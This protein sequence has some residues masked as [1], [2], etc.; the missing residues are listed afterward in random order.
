MPDLHISRGNS[1]IGYIPNVSLD[2]RKTCVDR[3]CRS[4][5]YALKGQCAAPDTRKA[6]AENYALYLNEPVTYFEEIRRFLRRRKPPVFRFH[7]GGDIPGP[8][9]LEAMR[10]L[11][12]NFRYTQFFCYTKAW[13][14]S[15][16]INRA[17]DQP[18]ASNLKIWLSVWPEH[19]YDGVSP[20]P[21]GLHGRFWTVDKAPYPAAKRCSG[22]C[23]TCQ[24]CWTA[25]RGTNIWI[26]KH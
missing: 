5:C 4:S 21:P 1:K 10:W 23:P 19:G 20:L 18:H 13:Y 6:W 9:Y 7:V 15:S 16:A 25:R 14:D 3:A 26:P 17:L 22:H 12:E 8:F 24:L 2:P 11:A